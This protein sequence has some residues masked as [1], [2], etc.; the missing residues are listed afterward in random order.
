MLVTITGGVASRLFLQDKR[1]SSAP[2]QS[3]TTRKSIPDFNDVDRRDVIR[4]AV[5]N[6]QV[7]LCFSSGF[8]NDGDLELLKVI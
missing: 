3:T 1:L 6:G 8:I 5:K 2:T 7:K 4:R